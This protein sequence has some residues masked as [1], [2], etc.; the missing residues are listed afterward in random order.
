M[1]LF[2]SAAAPGRL[3][4]AK[5]RLRAAILG[6]RADGGRGALIDYVSACVERRQ[7]RTEG[8]EVERSVVVHI[9]GIARRFH[10]LTVPS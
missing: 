5:A 2:G 9:L 1:F 3:I 7:K 4:R 8:C 10:L 6:R